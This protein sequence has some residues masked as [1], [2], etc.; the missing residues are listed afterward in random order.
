MKA[1]LGLRLADHGQHARVG[2]TEPEGQDVGPALPGGVGQA[3]VGRRQRSV[4]SVGRPSEMKI[5]A[6]RYHRSPPDRL[7]W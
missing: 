1:R 3:P 5:T 6:G 4:S 2:V 7:A